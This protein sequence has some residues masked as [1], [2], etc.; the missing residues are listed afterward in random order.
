[1]P[2]RPV[3]GKIRFHWGTTIPADEVFIRVYSSGFRLVRNF[4]FNSKN[5]SDQ[6]TAGTHDFDWDCTD[7][8]KRVLHPGTYLCFIEVKSGKTKFE[9][10]GQTE[11]P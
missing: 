6:L 5:D 3:D 2:A 8:V 11:I 4:E 1:V 10:N 9:A 7:D